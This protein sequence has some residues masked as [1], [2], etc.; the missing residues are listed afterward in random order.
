MHARMLQARENAYTASE[1]A[2]VNLSLGKR[3][4]INMRYLHDVKIAEVAHCSCRVVSA[5]ECNVQ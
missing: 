4:S 3:I 2:I 5:I 1:N